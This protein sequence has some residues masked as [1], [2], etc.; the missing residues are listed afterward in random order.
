M[1][2]FLEVDDLSVDELRRVMEL[3]VET[4][5]PKVLDGQGVA[6]VFEKP[7]G[8]TRN[9]MEMATVQLGGHPMYIK[10]EELGIDTRETA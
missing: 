6:L 9:S 1:R 8:R 2:H 4:N 10:P 5:L 3:S 7:S